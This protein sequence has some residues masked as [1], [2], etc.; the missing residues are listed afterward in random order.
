MLHCV[1]CL[2]AAMDGVLE[3]AVVLGGCKLACTFLFLPSLAV[4]HSPVSFC[5]CCLL[6]FTDLL[7][8]GFL[9]SLY[10]FESWLIDLSPSGDV[11]ALRFLVF[12]SHTYG[13]VL[14]LIT[15]LIALETLIRL[16]WSYVAVDHPTASQTGG[17]CYFVGGNVK[18][19]EDS[20]STDK[21]GN[22]PQ[23]VGFFCCLS[24]WFI[25]A[26]N[27]KWHWKIEEEWA[28]VCLHKTDSLVKCLPN[29]FSSMPSAPNL[30]WI[31]AFLSFF[32]VLLIISNFL[33]KRHQSSKQSDVQ[34]LM[35][36]HEDLF[37]IS[38]HYLSDKWGSGKYQRTNRDI[39]VAFLAGGQVDSQHTSWCGC[40]RWGF[41]RLEE[42]LMMVL[43]SVLSIVTL[44]FNLSVNILL[45]RT[46]D[47][48]LDWCIRALLQSAGTEN[49]RV[50]PTSQGVV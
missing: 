41:P 45:I 19:E 17:H 24:V 5:C 40:Q 20:S 33:Q 18:E 1:C 21:N 22:L 43:L 42:N 46:M 10:I 38:P 37:L 25:V 7:V 15:F 34:K 3:G 9:G 12:L 16:P 8:T 31:V 49:T 28:A 39:P 13:S 26:L 14:L 50:A 30:C 27:V 44:P 4:S 11:I 47:V 48:L 23:V 35:H 32:L 2:F 6:I 29:L 36:H